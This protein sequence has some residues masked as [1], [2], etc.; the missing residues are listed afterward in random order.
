VIRS[1]IIGVLERN[2]L[3]PASVGKPRDPGGEG[4]LSTLRL[5]ECNR[6]RG[7]QSYNHSLEYEKLTLLGPPGSLIEYGAFADK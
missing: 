2:G 1:I 4:L 6:Y 5:L 7:R 3:V